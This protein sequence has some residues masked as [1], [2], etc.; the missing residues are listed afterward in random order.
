[1]TRPVNLI[2]IDS[3]P[4]SRL[5]RKPPFLVRLLYMSL[6]VANPNKSSKTLMLPMTGRPIFTFPHDLKT[7]I[8][9][10][11][12]FAEHHLQSETIAFLA[13]FYKCLSLHSH[14]SSLDTVSSDSCTLDP[15]TYLTSNKD[16]PR[17]SGIPLCFILSSGSPHGSPGTA[18][19]M[20]RPGTVSA[21][22]LRCHE[23]MIHL[24]EGGG[25]SGGD[26][27]MR[28]EVRGHGVH[29]DARNN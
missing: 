21:I 12:F 4:V 5:C 25:S 24:W 2:Q 27:H 8:Y 16:P 29:T 19:V 1:M 11:Y 26:P 9:L 14:T 13:L 3:T 18:G 17:P 15:S 23:F 6:R 20:A 7:L 22:H 28:R 10:T